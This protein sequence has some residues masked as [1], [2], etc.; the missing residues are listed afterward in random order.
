[1]GPTFIIVLA[2]VLGVM[3]TVSGII[4]VW[5]AMRTAQHTQT[6]KNFR[7]AAASWREKAEAL[8]SD[9]AGMQQ[10]LAALRENYADL[11]HEHEVLKNVVTG[12]SALEALGVH[13]EQA[14]SDIILEVRMS[15]ETLENL[16]GE[17]HHDPT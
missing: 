12:K 7:E 15:R 11:L 6:V 17:H 8:A 9:L 16:I 1:M 13:L 3:L 10:E 14:K 4:G 5:L 2:A